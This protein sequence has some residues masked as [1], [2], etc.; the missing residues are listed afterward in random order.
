MAT[1]RKRGGRWQAQVRLKGQAPV[2]QS[3]GTK[4]EAEKWARQIEAAADQ[5]QSTDPQSQMAELRL[6][7]LLVRYAE[8]VTPAKKGSHSESYRLKTLRGHSIAQ[9]PLTKLNSAKVATYRDDRLKQVSSSS[10]RR[11]LTILRHCLQVAMVDWGIP[12]KANPA[13]EIKRPKEALSRDRRVS[14]EELEALRKALGVCRNPLV[15]CIVHFAIHT[16]M[17]RGEILAFRWCDVNTDERT[18]SL[19]NTKNGHPRT[20]PLS[21]AAIHALPVRPEGCKDTDRVFPMSANA[22]RLSWE[23]L[24]RRAGINDLHFHDLRHEAISRFFEL[25]LSIPEVS[26]ISGHKDAR[27]LFRYTHLKPVNVAEKLSKLMLE[28][29]PS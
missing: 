12:L 24:K 26:L 25:G 23:R 27:M 6:D 4:A 5:G 17:R 7:D 16:G 29:P 1:F 15:A 22:V 14:T 11:E 13:A 18:V 21:P 19:R 2:S 8:T 3:F 10:V 9:T 20:V 28:A